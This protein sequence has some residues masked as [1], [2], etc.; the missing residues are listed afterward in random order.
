MD[1]TGQMPVQGERRIGPSLVVL[2]LAALPFL[3]PAQ[4]FPA[5]AW[6]GGPLAVGLLVVVVVSDPGRI[7]GHSGLARWFSIALTFVLVLVSA[8]A[9]VALVVELVDGAP[10]L[11]DAATLLTTGALVW[12][13]VGLTF[14]LLYWELDGGGAAGRLHRGRQ[15]P[16][17]AFPEDLN[18]HLAVPGWRPTIIDYLYLAFT[19]ATAFSPTDVMPMRRWAKM[20]M[21]VQAMISL[22]LLS[23]VIANAVNIL[24]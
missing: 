2:V 12:I 1:D 13:D 23:L 4:V 11:Q 3:L 20:L 9:A 17:L 22:A 7:D 14:A 15:H 19:N 21:A 6:L 5:A 16:E 8:A 18:P 10:D 24:G